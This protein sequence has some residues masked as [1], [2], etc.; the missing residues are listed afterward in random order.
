MSDVTE[1]RKLRSAIRGLLDFPRYNVENYGG[2]AFS[3]ASPHA[4]NPVTA[5]TSATNYFNPSFQTFPE[6]VF[7]RED[8][9]FGALETFCLMRYIGLL[10][11]LLTYLRVK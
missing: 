2:R 1:R 8:I 5:R 10:T 4:R 7:I 3:Y 11:Y 6:N 9:A